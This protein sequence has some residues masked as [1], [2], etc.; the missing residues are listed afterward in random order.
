MILWSRCLVVITLRLHRRGRGFEP[1]RDL[2]YCS[3]FLK[4]SVYSLQYLNRFV[5]RIRNHYLMENLI[6]VMSILSVIIIL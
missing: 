2:Q 1:H 6:Q 5:F 3:K 4:K